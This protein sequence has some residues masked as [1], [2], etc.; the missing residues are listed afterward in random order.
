MNRKLETKGYCYVDCE[1]RVLT[2]RAVL[3]HDGDREAWLPRNQIED[4]DP[5]SL[6]PGQHVELLV[7]EWVAVEK[8]LV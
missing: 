6:E 1:I 8:G 2:E 5:A 3:V 7:A 4:P